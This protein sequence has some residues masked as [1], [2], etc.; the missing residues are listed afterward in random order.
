MWIRTFCVCGNDVVWQIA[1][2]ASSDSAF[3]CTRT[4]NQ[5]RI[6]TD[7]ST[8]A[9]YLNVV[10]DCATLEA[11]I[12]ETPKWNRSRIVS[13]PDWDV[14]GLPHPLQANVGVTTRLGHNC[15]VVLPS[16]R[17][18]DYIIRQA[19]CVLH[20]TVERSRIIFTSSAVLAVWY[21]F[22]RR[23][24]FY[25]TG[26]NKTCVYLHV[27]CRR[28]FCPILTKFEFSRQIFRESPISKLTEI[29]PVWTEQ[30]DMTKIIG[31]FREY[32][33]SA[34]KPNKCRSR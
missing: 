18:A 11:Y 28:Y 22:T 12:R 1:E 31:A 26:T 5:W 19:V 10:T 24:R 8:T 20:N 21:H 7:V 6:S 16:S 13:C 14:R 4:D 3:V 25:V 2:P 33:K 15:F 34:W 30:T 9:L 27:K 23:Q 29:R 17:C 32:A